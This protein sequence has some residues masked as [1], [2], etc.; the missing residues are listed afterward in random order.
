MRYRDIA[1]KEPE[2]LPIYYS[3]PRF[4]G[5]LLIH[6]FRDLKTYL[7]RK[8]SFLR[9]YIRTVS[10]T[11]IPVSIIF[12]V[13]AMIGVQHLSVLALLWS[14][15]IA[16]VGIIFAHGAKTSPFPGTLDKWIDKGILELDEKG[17]MK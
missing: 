2:I 17:N 9:S 4:I 16:L 10:I 6:F 3:I 1:E 11:L 14:T 8:D 12:C 15:F 7:K 5:F 13:S